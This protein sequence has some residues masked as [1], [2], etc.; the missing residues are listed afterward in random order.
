[1]TSPSTVGPNA[2]L[3]PCKNIPPPVTPPVPRRWSSVRHVVRRQYMN[4]QRLTLSAKLAVIA[5]VYNSFW[6]GVFYLLYRVKSGRY[7]REQLQELENN[8]RLAQ[9][10]RCYAAASQYRQECLAVEGPGLPVNEPCVAL[11]STLDQCRVGLADLVGSHLPPAM[12][13]PLQL[14]NR[15][16][17][18]IDPDWARDFAAAHQRPSSPYEQDGG[19]QEPM[20]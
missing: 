12:Q 8:V 11:E 17:W 9:D 1:M 6:A 2:S 14:R 13:P 15:P 19:D 18:V 16:H 7:H 10:F 20:R 4:F 5:V 3:P